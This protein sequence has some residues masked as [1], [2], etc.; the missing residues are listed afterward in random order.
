MRFG[1]GSHYHIF[2]KSCVLKHLSISLNVLDLWFFNISG[3]LRLKSR[4]S[5]ATGKRTVKK[6][7]VSNTFGTI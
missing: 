2:S 1:I 4:E 5:N 7:S 6:I 3:S